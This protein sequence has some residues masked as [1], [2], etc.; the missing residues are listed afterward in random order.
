MESLDNTDWDV[1]IVGTGLQQSILALALSRSG[2]KIL[3]VDERPYYSGAAAAFNL[4]EAEEWAAEVNQGLFYGAFANASIHES[5]PS[6]SGAP[7]LS[8]LP[9]RRYN[10]ALAPEIIYSGSA[11]RRY[12]VSSQAYHQVQFAPVGSWWVYTQK[13]S[14]GTSSKSVAMTGS[15]EKVPNT[16]E[17]LFGDKTLDFPTKRKLVKVLRFVLNYEDED[18]RAKWEE[19]RTLPFSSFL[20]ATFK[21]PVVLLAPLLA[22]TMSSKSPE[23][24]TTEYAL[25]RIARHLQSIGTLGHFSALSPRYGGLDEFCQVACRACAVGGGVYVLGKGLSTSNGSLSLVQ[26]PSREDKPEGQVQVVDKSINEGHAFTE[27]HS[28]QSSDPL[29]GTPSGETKKHVNTDSDGQA[30]ASIDKMAS[31]EQQKHVPRVKVHLK[32]GEAVTAQW[33]V[34]ESLPPQIGEP[35]CKSI[36]IVSSSLETLFPPV[37]S[38]DKVYQSG[39]A[40]LVFPSGSLSIAGYHQQDYPPVHIQAHSSE[41][42]ECPPGQSV[43]YASTSLGGERGFELLK[44]ATSSLMGSIDASPSPTVLWSMQYEQ[45]AM[46]YTLPLASPEGASAHFLNLSPTPL[47]LAVDDSVFSRVRDIWQAI[48]DEDPA[49]FLVFEKREEYD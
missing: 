2:K 33:I 27:G 45:R 18:E 34:Y 23:S 28:S 16:R 42:A 14:P 13:G 19:H 32:D 38:T 6:E 9:G 10:L 4:K 20:S 37:H 48:T 36:T 12:L 3:H 17:D 8:R 39:S 25:P 11:F 24:M 30:E 7:T 43:L 26:V 41:S 40:I 44:Q 31:V 5:E 22:L 35:S 46:P 47:D 1:L 49:Q 29:D 15:L 21:T